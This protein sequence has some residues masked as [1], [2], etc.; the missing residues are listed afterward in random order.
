MFKGD[1]AGRRLIDWHWLC[2]PRHHGEEVIE[3]PLILPFD[4]DLAPIKPFLSSIHLSNFI[5]VLTT[6]LRA[7]P[8]SPPSSDHRFSIVCG[9]HVR[10]H[11]AHLY[12]L[13]SS[14]P[15]AS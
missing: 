5:R 3:L 12:P 15:F 10:H 13:D 11:R 9:V 6:L 4:P 8:I 7:K 2:Q 14:M 1:T